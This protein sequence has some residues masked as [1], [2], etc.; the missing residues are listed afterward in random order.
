MFTLTT[1]ILLTQVRK[2]PDITQSDGI[3]DNAE[4]KLHLSRPGR[5]ITILLIA[6]ATRT[7]RAPLR[8]W[9]HDCYPMCTVPP[10]SRI[11]WGHFVSI[12]W[13]VNA[14]EFGCHCWVNDF[15]RS[16]LIDASSTLCGRQTHNQLFCWKYIQ[17]KVFRLVK[18]KER[19][20][21]LVIF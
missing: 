14:F 9:Q 5:P 18:R 16:P 3:S 15:D 1:T 10:C 8:R 12:A 4:K 21:E 13:A 2:S 19:K 7:D 6:V 20:I 11:Q 17:K